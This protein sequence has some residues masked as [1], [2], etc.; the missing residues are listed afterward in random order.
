MAFIVVSL[1]DFMWGLDI[2]RKQEGFKD[3]VFERAD[4]KSSEM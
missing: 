4:F 2:N 1:A 3:S